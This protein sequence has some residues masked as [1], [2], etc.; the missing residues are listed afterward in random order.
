MNNSFLAIENV[1][2]KN[3]FCDKVTEHDYNAHHCYILKEIADS[4]LLRLA[5]PLLRRH[6]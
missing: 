2:K 6:K 1:E 4:I 5:T 3:T